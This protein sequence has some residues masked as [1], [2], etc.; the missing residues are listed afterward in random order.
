MWRAHTRDVEPASLT[1]ALSAAV[2]PFGWHGTPTPAGW[3]SS[4]RSAS[5]PSWLRPSSCSSAVGPSTPSWPATLRCRR[6]AGSCSLSRQ[7]GGVDL[8]TGRWQRVAPARAFLRDAPLVVLDEPTA[9]LDPRA[10]RDL[11]QT[12]AALYQARAY[13]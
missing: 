8:S 11:F 5:V 10:E 9:A 6:P 4:A 13:R 7:L 12:V 2:G 3:S 1:V